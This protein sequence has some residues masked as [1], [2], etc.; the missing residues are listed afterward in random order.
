MMKFRVFVVLGLIITGSAVFAQSGSSY[1]RIGIGDLEYSNSARK[2]GIGN[3]GVSVADP[4]FISLVN[5]AGIYR[6]KRTRIETGLDYYGVFTSNN[7]GSTYQG[8]G[9]FSGFNL[10]FPVS[11]VHG[12]SAAIGIVPYSNVSYKLKEDI[13]SGVDAGQEYRIFYE[14]SGGLTKLYVAASYMLPFGLVAGAS[15]DYYFGNL[16]YFSRTDFFNTSILDAEYERTFSPKSLGG[17]FGLISPDMSELIGSKNISDFRI[18]AA[19]SFISKLDADTVFVATSSIET[20]TIA[21]GTGTMDIPARF[22]VGA[23]FVLNSKYLFTLD[24]VFQQWSKYKLFDKTDPRLRD[25]MKLSGGFEYRPVREPGS[26]SWQQIIWRAGLSYEQTQ[27]DVL[28]T[29]I[30]QFSVSGGFSFPIS[31]ENTIDI[32]LQY[33]MRGKKEDGLFKE[34]T[35]RL[36]VGISLGDIWF[37]RQDK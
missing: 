36:G 8:E 25:A 23:S 30:N 21:K 16:N 12:I 14:G 27:Y 6:L 15:F 33:S 1:T 18:G 22:S 11:G 10:A 28:N 13:T 17:S 5:P 19:A 26:T 31:F 24:Y 7:N 34:N 3:L 9:E 20:D 35:I 37:L 4:D 2:L 32:G 29:G